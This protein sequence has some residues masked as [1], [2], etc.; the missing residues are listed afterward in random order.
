MPASLVGWLM[1]PSYENTGA[2]KRIQYLLLDLLQLLLASQQLAVFH[3]ERNDALRK[4]FGGGRNNSDL[5]VKKRKGL[6]FVLHTLDVRVLVCIS[7]YS[8][9]S[10]V[11]VIL[12]LS[13]S[14]RDS[15]LLKGFTLFD[16]RH[17]PR[18]TANQYSYIGRRSR[19][20]LCRFRRPL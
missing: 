17:V 13:H 14:H 4:D 6:C 7:L 10:S 12:S 16:C 5:A 19:A 15:A 11:R 2:P 18:P 1:L 20:I 3:I 8:I 9:P